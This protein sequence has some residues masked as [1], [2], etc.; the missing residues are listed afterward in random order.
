MSLRRRSWTGSVRRSD[1]T[2]LAVGWR[3]AR[4]C[5][6]SRL[7]RPP[8]NDSCHLAQSRT[9]AARRGKRQSCGVD[10]TRPRDLREQPRRRHHVADE[11]DALTYAGSRWAKELSA[12]GTSCPDHFLRTRVCPMFL[13]WDPA[14]IVVSALRALGPAAT[15]D[16]IDDY[17]NNYINRPP[18]DYGHAA[19]VRGFIY[20]ILR[21]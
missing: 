17:I 10:R 15:G 13:S 19:P 1:G 11:E 4:A 2:A 3:Q 12:L 16:Q 21:Q 7:G 8:A 9:T 14:K 18:R 6:A 20:Y 5:D